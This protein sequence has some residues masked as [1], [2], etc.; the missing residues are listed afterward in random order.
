M[1][2][3]FVARSYAYRATIAL[4]YNLGDVCVVCTDFTPPIAGKTVIETLLLCVFQGGGG[5]EIL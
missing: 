1:P 2:G 3:F 4:E 5:G